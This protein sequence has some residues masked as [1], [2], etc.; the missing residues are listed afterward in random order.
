MA[1]AVPVMFQRL[2]PPAWLSSASCDG[3]GWVSALSSVLSLPSP[4]PVQ[5]CSSPVPAAAVA[6]GQSHP[7]QGCCVET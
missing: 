1:A 2:D 5:H 4:G 6:G 7:G 3:C